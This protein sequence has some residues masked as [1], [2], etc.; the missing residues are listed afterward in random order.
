MPVS[1]DQLK[2]I[3][4]IFIAVSIICAVFAFLQIYILPADFLV[5]FGYSEIPARR[6]QL[7]PT[8]KIPAIWNDFGLNRAFSFFSGPNNFGFY[9]TISILVLVSLALYEKRQKLK[10]IL[11][12][13]AIGEVFILAQTFS[14]SAWL[15][16]A[17]ALFIL[18]ILA[19]RKKEFRVSFLII[20]MGFVFIASIFTRVNLFDKNQLERVV[21]HGH[22]KESTGEISGSTKAHLKSYQS[23]Y[24]LI[25]E[26]FIFGVGMG[27][28]NAAATRFSGGYSVESWY[29]Q[30]VLEM[31]IL[32]LLCFFEPFTT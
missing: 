20:I 2:G 15:G 27:K 21:L 9:L 24:Q 4:K 3:L 17:G 18:M 8:G 16:T 32:A 22:I 23:A 26:N 1:K 19:F 6:A 14:R 13:L 10:L 28:V 25:L 29:L 12:G 7:D 31:G 5:H 30:V 11:M